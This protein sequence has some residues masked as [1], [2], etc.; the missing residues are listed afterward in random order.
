MDRRKSC[1][2]RRESVARVTFLETGRLLFRA[3]E[4]CDEETF[5][6]MHGD[7]DVRQFVGGRPW[8]ADEARSRFHAQY[9]H[10][11]RRT[12]GL[13]ATILEGEDAYVGM[14]GLHGGKSAAHL[15][16]Y[17]ARPYWGRG[18]ATE[19]AHAF[20]D[21]GFRRLHLSRI[22]ATADERNARSR[23]ILATL[24]FAETR[25]EKLGSGR[26]LLHYQH[27]APEPDA[28]SAPACDER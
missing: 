24:G 18:I 3:H 17:L 16:F 26:V 9:L 13:W 8:P 4:A 22:L 5:V 11:P 21:V 7:P 14:C 23:R 25:S 6:L 20:L 12:Y 1:T 28:P 19:A 15:A 27:R 2:R 10:R